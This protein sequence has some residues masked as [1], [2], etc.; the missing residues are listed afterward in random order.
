MRLLELPVEARR[1]GARVTPKHTVVE[2]D[3]IVGQGLPVARHA[4]SESDFCSFRAQ[5]KGPESAPEWIY[6]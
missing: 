2:P 4:V 3:F 1:E 5:Q 6:C